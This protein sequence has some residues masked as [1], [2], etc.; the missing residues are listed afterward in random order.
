MNDFT[1]NANEVYEAFLDFNSKEMAKALK[2][3]LKKSL[4]NLRND[5]RKRLKTLFKNTNVIRPPF[6][7]SL[8]QGIRVSKLKEENHVF[9]GVVRSHS[10]NKHGSGSYRLPMLDGGT[11]ERWVSKRN[12]TTLKKPAYRGRIVGGRFFQDAMLNADKDFTNTLIKETKKVVD[13]IN[14]KK[15]W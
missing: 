3:G 10:N 4:N 13:K 6:N 2:G 5:A 9:S 15:Q 12:G 1:T 7:D 8:R 14:N 11:K